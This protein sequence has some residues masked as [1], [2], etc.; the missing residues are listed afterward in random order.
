VLNLCGGC[1]G[2]ETLEVLPHE[3][4]TRAEKVQRKTKPIGGRVGAHDL[5]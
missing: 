1:A 5:V 2:I 4:F 3:V